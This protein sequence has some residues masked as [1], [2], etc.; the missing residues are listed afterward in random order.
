L[1]E[2]QEIYK[3]FLSET[4]TILSRLD[5][6]AVNAAIQVSSMMDE[7]R[8]LIDKREKELLENIERERVSQEL[9][10]TLG[11]K[12]IESLMESINQCIN[13]SN[14]LLSF[15]NFAEISSTGKAVISRITS[16]LSSTIPT[17][18]M[19]DI[20]A[21]QFSKDNQET[22]HDILSSF[23]QISSM[24]LPSFLKTY[25]NEVIFHFLF[26]FALC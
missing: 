7:L 2:R 23:G 14:Q 26:C 24:E 8:A 1:A 15:G 9:K 16:L 3:E 6:D 4:N 13:Y 12:R 5:L 17:V 11:R 20:P 10:L 19:G 21:F 18:Q 25:W 22:L